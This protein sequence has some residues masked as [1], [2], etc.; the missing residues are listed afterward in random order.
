VAQIKGYEAAVTNFYDM[1]KEKPG[2]LFDPKTRIKDCEACTPSTNTMGNGKVGLKQWNVVENQSLPKPIADSADTA[3]NDTA[4]TTCNS[5]AGTVASCPAT[6]SETVLFWYELLKTGLI[7][8][9]TDEGVTSSDA[10]TIGG[11]VPAMRVGGGFWAGN[12]SGQN[13]D[14]TT[15][16]KDSTEGLGV[17]GTILVTV[18]KATT[19]PSTATGTQVLYA[20]DA[21][22]IDRKIDDGLPNSGNVESYGS[23]YSS[24]T[25]TGCVTGTDKSDIYAE[26]INSKDCGLIIRVFK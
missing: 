5:S 7:S 8:G 9:V 20:K 15:L 23:T 17:R 13:A 16:G 14:S 4:V 2:D 24:T 26:N 1:Y 21:A 12:S 3:L 19:P 25:S 10:A 18:L 6:A 22:N 11:T